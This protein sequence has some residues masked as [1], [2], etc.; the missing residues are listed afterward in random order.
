VLSLMSWKYAVAVIG[1]I[2]LAVGL[3]VPLEHGAVFAEPATWA[4]TLVGLGI[5]G[6]RLRSRGLAR[7]AAAPAETARARLG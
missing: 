6:F 7:R 5:I 3:V 4:I 2:C 1:A